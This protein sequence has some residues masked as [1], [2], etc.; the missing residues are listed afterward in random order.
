MDRIQQIGL[1]ILALGTLVLVLS[2][3]VP[4]PMWYVDDPFFLPKPTDNFDNISVKDPSIVYYGGKYHLFYTARNN[5]AFCIGYASAPTIDSLGKVQRRAIA[6]SNPAPCVFYFK[7]KSLWYMICNGCAYSTTSN[8][9]DPTSWSAPKSF[10]VDGCWDGWVICDSA[11][12]HIYYTKDFNVQIFHRKTPIAQ[13]PSGWGAETFAFT[14]FEAALVY[15]CKSDGKYYAIPENLQ[16]WG[17]SYRYF[18]LYTASSLDGPWTQISDAWA[19]RYSPLSFSGTRCTDA[20]SHGELILS[21]Y[22]QFMEIDD[23]N[24]TD[25][26]IQGVMAT[27]IAAAPNYEMIP[28]KL[29]MIHNYTRSTAIISLHETSEQDPILNR[30]S[31]QGDYGMRLVTPSGRLVSNNPAYLAHG[32]YFVSAPS[33]IRTANMLN[34]NSGK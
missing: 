32:R 29:G 6:I 11:Y 24:H 7:P 33:T 18:M 21:G 2:A 12:A 9:S 27:A 19:S 4:K 8:I 28:W 26:L 3:P 25:F 15:K 10:G 30:L 17:G 23:I 31:T 14:G 1:A 5:T 20:V 22:D 13:F 34:L 16:K